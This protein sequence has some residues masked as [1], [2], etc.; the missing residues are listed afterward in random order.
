MTAA[1]KAAHNDEDTWEAIKT[2]ARERNIEAGWVSMFSL[3]TDFRF[4]EV[5]LWAKGEYGL[6]ENYEPADPTAFEQAFE[7]IPLRLGEWMYDACR[8]LQ[9]FDWVANFQNN[10]KG[11]LTHPTGWTWSGHWLNVPWDKVKELSEKV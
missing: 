2:V 6:K 3:F 4:V 1:N 9:E 7:H 8:A 5:E 11:T 10:G